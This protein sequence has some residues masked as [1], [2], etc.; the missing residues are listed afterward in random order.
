[1]LSNINK[2]AFFKIFYFSSLFS[3]KPMQKRPVDLYNPYLYTFVSVCVKKYMCIQKKMRRNSQEKNIC[4]RV[5]RKSSA[6]FQVVQ[7]YATDF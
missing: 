7:I 4:Y 1:M 2:Y 6:S 3:I 5:G